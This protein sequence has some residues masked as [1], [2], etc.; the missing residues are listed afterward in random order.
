MAELHLWFKKQNSLINLR[1]SDVTSTRN[2]SLT[3]DAASTACLAG[4]FQ[5]FFTVCLFFFFLRLFQGF[6]FV[7][8]E[9]ALRSVVLC[10]LC[11]CFFP[12]SSIFHLTLSIFL[13]FCVIP[14]FRDSYIRSTCWTFFLFFFLFAFFHFS[15]S[16]S[17]LS[18][19]SS[20]STSSS[21][22]CFFSSDILGVFFIIYIEFRCKGSFGSDAEGQDISQHMPSPPLPVDHLDILTSTHPSTSTTFSLSF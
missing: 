11:C 3:N 17:C 22:P 13:L 12:F 4:A 2:C 10:P 18:F 9:I 8:E 14:F 6:V 19:P 20:S 15:T 16:H 1:I 7:M 21:C 5:F